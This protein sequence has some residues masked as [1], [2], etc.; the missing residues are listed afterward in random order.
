MKMNFITMK[1][2]IVLFAAIITIGFFPLLFISFK[3]INLEV[4]RSRRIMLQSVPFVLIVA[5][6]LLLVFGDIIAKIILK[7]FF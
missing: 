6:F 4:L 3:A 7:Y 2:W 5:W 1:F